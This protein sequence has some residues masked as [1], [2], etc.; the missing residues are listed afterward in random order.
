MPSGKRS[1][2]VKDIVLYKDSLD[3]AR[4]DQAVT[5]T[6]EDE[7]DISRGDIICRTDEP[8]E[9]ADQFQAH[10]IWMDDTRLFPGRQYIIRTSVQPIHLRPARLR[11]LSTGLMWLISQKLRP[12]R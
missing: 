8:N 5:I 6:L 3:H 2:K 12:R 10:L 11:R 9:V 1:N 7:I 4:M